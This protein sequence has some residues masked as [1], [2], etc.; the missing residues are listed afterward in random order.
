MKALFVHDHKFKRDPV[1]GLYYTTG[2]LN[3]NLWQRYLNIF[4]SVTV[5][6]RYDGDI[7]PEDNF[8]L[9]SQECV[10][11]NLFERTL[12]FRD[13]SIGSSYFSKR[14]KSLVRSHDAVIAR[15]PSRLG[16][17]FIKECQKQNKPYA[18][19]V[20]GS[21]WDA[22]WNYG[23]VSGKL[24]APILELKTKKAVYNAP[25]A[26]Y[27][28]K[29]FL[30][31]RYPCENGVTA[32]SSNAE[33][34]AVE[35]TILKT[36]L[37]KIQSKSASDKI[38]FGLIG[39]YSADY[40]GID[41]AIRALAIISKHSTN[42]EFQV[43]GEGDPKKYIA[44]AKKFKIEKNINFIGRLPSGEPILNWLDNID[45]Y[46]QPSLVEGLPRALI[47]AMSRGCPSLG[48]K[49]GGI[50]ELLN[51]SQISKPGKHIS[52]SKNILAILNNK[53]IMME[54]ANQNFEKASHY[55]S[56]V[57]SQRRYNFWKAFGNYVYKKKF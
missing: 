53:I 11:F 15:L 52:L 57:L 20:V 25:F 28:T 23:S 41:T 18:V 10:N 14:C 36:R 13:E 55:Y 19:E 6:A 1:K 46:L 47:E 16:L 39:N 56:S 34:V 32:Y 51:D 17:V 3:S 9:A 22:L 7:H 31:K 49:V 33:V 24:Y 8:P 30:Q 38:I 37:E 48:S 35:D 43:V 5:V 40:K 29:H 12:S 26:T 4:S 42:W 44:L 27:V 21:A 2:T 50:P 54:L 45:I